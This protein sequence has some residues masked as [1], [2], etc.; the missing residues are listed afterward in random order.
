MAQQF[1][2]KDVGQYQPAV[3]QLSI[4]APGQA[5]AELATYTFPLTP[6]LLRTERNAMSTPYDTQGPST[7]DG[8]TRN[9]DVYGLTPPTFVIEGT[10]GWDLHSSDGYVLTG[11]Q[12]IMLLQQFLAR[13]TQLNQRQRETGN[14]AL[15]ALEFYDYFL[16]SFWQIEPIGPQGIRQSVDRTKLVYYRFR[17]A[18]VQPVG[19]P[20][21]GELDA[22][23]TTFATPAT[24][25]A[26]AAARTLGAMTVAYGPAGVAGSLP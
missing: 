11:L 1:R 14:P 15:F 21:L 8:V 24:T 17:W 19:V 16:D 10:T 6:T 20:I 4:R 22:L 18:G 26:V 5:F 12:S 7:T 3:Y 13:Y 23:A 25:A 2:N 9:V